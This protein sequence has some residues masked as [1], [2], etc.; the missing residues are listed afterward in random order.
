M[1]KVMSFSAEPELQA[2]LKAYAKSQGESYSEC[3]RTLINKYV[4]DDNHILVVMK[5]PVELKGDSAAAKTWFDARVK[6]I[7]AKWSKNE[8]A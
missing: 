2:K 5:V 4:V 1:S 3:I 8:E 6:G 7:L